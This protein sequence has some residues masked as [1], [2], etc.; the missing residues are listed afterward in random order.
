MAA[1]VAST[2]GTAAAAA[3]WLSINELLA[4]AGS[5]VDMTQMIFAG[6]FVQRRILH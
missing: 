2:E 6:K 4:A 5:S 1:A 3:R